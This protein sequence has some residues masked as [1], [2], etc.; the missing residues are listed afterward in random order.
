M[1]HLIILEQVCQP[2]Y[3]RGSLLEFGKPTGSFSE[4]KMFLYE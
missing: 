1:T 4:I 2:F 3:D